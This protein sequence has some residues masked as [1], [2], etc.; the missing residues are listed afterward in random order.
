[1]IFRQKVGKSGCMAKEYIRAGFIRGLWEFQGFGDFGVLGVLGILRFRGFGGFG[2][3]WGS[4]WFGGF[5]A[6]GGG[7]SSRIPAGVTSGALHQKFGCGCFIRH[8][9]LLQAP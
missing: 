9:L 1:M 6:F 4:G 3:F 7:R 8:Y 2:G 5:G